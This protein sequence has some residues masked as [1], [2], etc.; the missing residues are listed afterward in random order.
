MLNFEEISK[1]TEEMKDKSYFDSML[2]VEEILK[3]SEKIVIVDPA[4]RSHE[5]YLI[6][7]VPEPTDSELMDVLESELKRCKNPIRRQQLQ[8]N[9]QELKIKVKL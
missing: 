9:I 7:T 4:R 1:D 5:F 3:I 6:Y 8:R 2:S